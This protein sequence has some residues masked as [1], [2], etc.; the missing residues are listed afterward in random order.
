[1]NTV[2]TYSTATCLIAIWLDL[3]FAAIK[4]SILDSFCYVESLTHYILA[5]I[6]TDDEENDSEPE[7]LE[8]TDLE[9]NRSLCLQRGNLNVKQ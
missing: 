6:K 2:Q 1:M 4:Y 9:E 5:P 8:E 7:I 3:I